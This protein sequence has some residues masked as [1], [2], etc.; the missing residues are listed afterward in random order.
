MRFTARWH[1]SPAAHDLRD[2]V[3]GEWRYVRR[4]WPS[5]HACVTASAVWRSSR[6][7]MP[8]MTAVLATLTRTTWSKPTLLYE[9]SRARQPWI[10]C[11]L[12]MP[13]RTSR[14]VKILPPARLPPALLVRLTQS[15]TARM[16]PRLS[17]GWPH[18]AASQQSL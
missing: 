14:M 11:A 12:I 8:E 13:S 17:E 7:S 5:T 10:S 15:A 18:S 2:M 1:A 4:L 6:P 3:L 16:A 9:F